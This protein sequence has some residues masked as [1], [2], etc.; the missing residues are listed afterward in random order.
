MS[1]DKKVACFDFDGVIHRYNGYGRGEL[2]SPLKEGLDLMSRFF[3]HDY[4]I[5]VYTG[6]NNKKHS[7]WKEQQQYV[8]DWLDHYNVPY[9]RLV[10]DG[11]GKPIANVYFDDRSI[12]VPKNYKNIGR[13][14]LYLQY[15]GKKDHDIDIATVLYQ[16]GLELAEEEI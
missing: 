4:E 6:R 16:A 14:P 9:T 5:L 8:Q 13:H 12:S 10:S 7:H 2:G 15:A 1:E 11:D 3:A